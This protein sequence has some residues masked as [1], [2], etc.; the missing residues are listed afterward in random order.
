[1]RSHLFAAA[2]A[3]ALLVCAFFYGGLAG[4]GTAVVLS[5]LELSLSF[6]NAVLNATVLRRMTPVWQQLFLTLGIVVAVFVVRMVLP[7]LLVSATSRISPTSALRL[8]LQHPHQYRIAVDAGRL[9]LASFGA[10]F[11][12]LVAGRFL[13]ADHDI[14]WL[15][16]ERLVRRAVRGPRGALVVVTVVALL[17]VQGFG[18]NAL[19][20][21]AGAL[22]GLIAFV[23]LA[24]LT[25]KTSGGLA[26]TSTVGFA[27]FV[28]LELL[29]ASVSMDGVIGA[30]AVTT[31]VVLM[32]IGLGV[33]ALF[34]RSTTVVL[35][36]SG[37]LAEYA[38]LEHGAYY[39]IGS[40]G[41]F[42]ALSVRWE[43]PSPVT[44]AVGMALI[45]LSLLSSIRNPV[46]D[47]GV[48]LQSGQPS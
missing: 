10:T 43:I 35:A 4:L 6:D 36:R 44:A 3:A 8:A 47:P 29:D 5:V 16:V 22:A 40:L 30:F 28:Y 14:S 48:S 25:A 39:A 26:T 15:R 1:M 17:C 38:F 24:A 34:V 46:K 13:A 12:I 19:H 41:V 7:L 37:R 2:A 27:G 45:G 11:L 31:D 9:V 42:L 20:T 18:R 21:T 23:G 33:G 32:A